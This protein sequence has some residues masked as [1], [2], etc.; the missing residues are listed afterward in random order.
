MQSQLRWA[1]YVA[2]MAD[3]RLPKTLFY[4]ELQEGKRSQGGQKKPFKDNLNISVKAFAINPNTWEHT[5][6]DRAEW[7]SSLYKGAATCEANITA[8]AEKRRQ[9]R[10]SRISGP[11]TAHAAATPV[12]TARESSLLTYQPSP[13][14]P[15]MTEVVLIASRWT[16][17]RCLVCGNLAAQCLLYSERKQFEN[18]LHL[19][20]L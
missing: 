19:A 3:H 14:N 6:Q 8:A 17:E 1:G 16:N 13:L 4:G 12:H 7:R 11:L 20:F 10:K 5:A 2:R 9:A 18:K 15:R